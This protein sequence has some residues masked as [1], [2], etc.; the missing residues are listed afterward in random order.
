MYNLSNAKVGDKFLTW[1]GEERELEYISQSKKMYCMADDDGD[2]SVYDAEGLAKGLYC[3]IADSLT[4]SPQSLETI[5]LALRAYEELEF[6]TRDIVKADT[7]WQAYCS[8]LSRVLEEEVN[9]LTTGERSLV[10][11]FSE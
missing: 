1:L 11:M 2:I 6:S 5:T 9:L 7:H 4:S 10:R 3:D 8:L